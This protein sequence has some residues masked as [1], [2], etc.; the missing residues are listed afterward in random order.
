MLTKEL[1]IA[2]VGL[3]GIILISVAIFV[4]KTPN[5]NLSDIT[6]QKVLSKSPQPPVSS[7]S[8]DDDLFK[9]KAEC[10]SHKGDIEN[11]LAAT[12]WSWYLIAEVFYSPI[13]SSCFYAVNAYQNRGSYSAFIIWDYFTGEM[14]FYRDT[15]LTEN[16]NIEDMY[17]NARKYLK[18]EENLK[19][20][21]AD[22]E[23]SE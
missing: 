22:W 6:K 14:I 13:K 2:I 7:S 5:L 1:K 19:Y 20:N 3:G 12:Q 18:S 8:Q 10:A 11:K 16:Q 9:I 15:T 4:W 17:R 23:L 21:E